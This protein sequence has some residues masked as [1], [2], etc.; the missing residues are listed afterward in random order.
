MIHRLAQVFSDSNS[1][2]RAKLFGIYGIF[3]ASRALSGML[4]RWKG[5]DRIEVNPK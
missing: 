3:I 5:F 2:V 4:Y 1:H